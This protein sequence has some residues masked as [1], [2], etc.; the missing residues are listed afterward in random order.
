MQVTQSS[1][2]NS[3][4]IV[5]QDTSLFHQSI[6]YNIKYGSMDATQEQVETAAKA[7]QVLSL[8]ALN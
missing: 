2:R 1:L 5:P 6:L 4:G 8:F 3:I 7:A